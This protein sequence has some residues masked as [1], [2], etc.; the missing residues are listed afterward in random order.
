MTTCKGTDPSKPNCWMYP[1]PGG[2]WRCFRFGTPAETATW[3]TS[4]GGWVTCAVNLT[5]SFEQVQK[6]FG[7]VRLP[8]TDK[9]GLVFTD[10]AQANAAV[11]AYGGTLGLPA[12]AENWAQSRPSRSSGA[13]AAGC[14]RSSSTRKMTK[15][16]EAT[17]RRSRPIGRK[18]AVPSGRR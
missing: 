18:H 4:P 13:E 17:W 3:E 14:W 12:W 15:G 5:P 10:V 16:G 9:E 11:A 7:A 2:A 1:L 6:A 8:S